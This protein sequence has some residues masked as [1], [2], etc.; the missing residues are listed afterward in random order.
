MS[1][2]LFIISQL[3]HK[4]PLSP[5]HSTPQTAQ[6]DKNSLMTILI[7]LPWTLF[8]PPTASLGQ[9]KITILNNSGI[10]NNQNDLGEKRK[11][12]VEDSNFLILKLT[13]KLQL[14]KQCGTS[15][16]IDRNPQK[17]R[18]SRNKAIHLR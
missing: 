17:K 4:L 16:S 8:K 6:T 12:K 5:Y 18:K 2:L 10:V 14:S 15:I 7:S 1:P 11:T 9:T 13:I 3:D